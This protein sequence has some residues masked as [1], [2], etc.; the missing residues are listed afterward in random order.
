MIKYFRDSI[1]GQ[2][3]ELHV[4]GERFVVYINTVPNYMTNGHL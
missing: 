3:A 4:V 1:Q 2:M